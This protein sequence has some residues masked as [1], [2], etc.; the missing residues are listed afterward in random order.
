MIFTIDAF[1]RGV[2][3]VFREL[4]P[5][6]EFAGFHEYRVLSGTGATGYELQPVDAVKMP[7]LQGVKVW[8][9]GSA[10][11]TFIPG[12]SVLVAFVN[13]DPGRA[14]IAFDGAI[15]RHGDP[16]GAVTPGAY[17]VQK[18]PPP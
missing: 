17:V 14:F 10:T 1:K 4:D 18:V 7:P 12:A 16:L 11:T 13:K 9:K 8:P 2:A 15:V 3:A 5:N 6:R